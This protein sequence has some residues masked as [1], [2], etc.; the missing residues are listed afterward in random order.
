MPLAERRIC[1]LRGALLRIALGGESM[2][3]PRMTELHRR[4]ARRQ[5]LAKLRRK[6]RQAKTQDEK[7]KILA[8]AARVSPTAKLD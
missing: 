1:S 6:Y 7:Q 2:P 4:R 8:K 3:L 5:K